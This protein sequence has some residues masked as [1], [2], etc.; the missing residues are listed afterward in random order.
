MLKY[1]LLAAAL[2][3]LTSSF[4]LAAPPSETDPSAPALITLSGEGVVEGRPDIARISLGVSA[5]APTARAA[6]ARD[7]EQ[8]TAVLSALKAAGLEARDIQTSSISLSAQ[9]DYEPNKPARL[10]GYGAANSVQITVRAID[11]TGAVLDAAAGAGANQVNGISFDLSHREKL[12]DEARLAAVKDLEARAHL[13]AAALGKAHLKLVR[14]SE[15]GAEPVMRTPGVLQAY[16]V[17]SAAAAPP[18][19]EAGEQTVRIA[20]TGV[21]ALSD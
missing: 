6:M 20:I 1:G 15:G 13:Y 2:G 10:T 5:T 14:L 12:A 9:Y 21:Y 18:P 19:I 16:A 7:A 17:R 4:A 3:L 8:M 11:Q